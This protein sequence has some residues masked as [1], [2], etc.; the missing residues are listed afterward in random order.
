MGDEAPQPARAACTVPPG[1]PVALLGPRKGARSR[2]PL[3]SS[4]TPHSRWAG[5]VSHSPTFAR[6]SKALRRASRPILEPFRAALRL[7]GFVLASRRDFQLYS[8]PEYFY[9]FSSDR[10]AATRLQRT[11]R[12][13]LSS[14]PTPFLGLKYFQCKFYHDFTS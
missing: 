5:G 6:S 3:R 2:S 7:P 9:P 4:R 13:H 1:L 11:F 8:S 12:V 14:L 10:P